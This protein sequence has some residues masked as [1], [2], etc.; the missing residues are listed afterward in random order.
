MIRQA[1]NLGRLG[2][3]RTLRYK[4]KPRPTE[5]VRCCFC[6]KPLPKGG[7]IRFKDPRDDQWKTRCVPDGK[8]SGW[9]W[10]IVI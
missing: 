3:T 9:M 7:S 10:P 1:S 5:P 2:E 8:C 6:S 4:S